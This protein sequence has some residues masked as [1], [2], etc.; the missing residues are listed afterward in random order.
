MMDASQ[1]DSKRSGWQGLTAGRRTALGASVATVS[2]A[3]MGAATMAVVA[4]FAT[5]ATLLAAI[6]ALVSALAALV[7]A[8]LTARLA[9]TRVALIPLKI[10]SASA[11]ATSAAILALLGIFPFAAGLAGS[12]GL[13]RGGRTAEE[14]P[15]PS[16]EAARFL[17]RLR[18]G[19]RSEF[20]RA[21]L[22][23]GG[24]TLLIPSRTC[25]GARIGRPVIPAVPLWAED[26]PLVAAVITRRTRGVGGPTR[27]PGGLVRDVAEGFAFPIMFDA[28]GRLGRKDLQ[29]RHRFR[30]R[31]SDS[32]WILVG[33]PDR[34]AGGWTDRGGSFGN[35]S[36]R[37][38]SRHRSW[39][40]WRQVGHGWRGFHGS[41]HGGRRSERV[42]VFGRRGDD[43]H[44]SWLV[45]GRGS[46][47]SS[48]NGLAGRAFA[49][50]EAG[51]AVVAERAG[52]RGGVWWRA[53][54]A[55]RPGSRG[56][57]AGRFWI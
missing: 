7:S 52:G 16:E 6:A 18:L 8:G 38:R 54:C 2:A 13:R 26:G 30:L 25:L 10:A 9:V 12:L 29:F 17:G 57:G 14:F 28:L 1:C 45:F 20:G 48:L 55:R 44:R 41:G 22:I 11:P 21:G 43:G 51:A 53:W 31:R 5:V 35:R 3:A 23:A 56:C 39:R 15:Q 47:G 49:A 37:K 42:L 19:R 46:G 24:T 34:L 27:L 32:N 50:G 36:C 4:V 33:N 40:R